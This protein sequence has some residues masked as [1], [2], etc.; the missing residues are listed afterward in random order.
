ME[1]EH[2][3]VANSTDEDGKDGVVDVLPAAGGALTERSR[4]FS[5]TSLAVSMQVGLT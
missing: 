4:A 2:G 3:K 1:P 5:S